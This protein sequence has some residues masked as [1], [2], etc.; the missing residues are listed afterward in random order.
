MVRTLASGVLRLLAWTCRLFAILYAAMALAL[1]FGPVSALTPVA[2]LAFWL[3]SLIPGALSGLF[4]WISPLGGSFRGDFAI[5]AIVLF[6]ADWAL[7]RASV[8]VR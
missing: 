5:C 7:V 1:C 2:D 8:A 4:V 6:I 3:Q